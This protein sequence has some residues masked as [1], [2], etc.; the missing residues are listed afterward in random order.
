MG[1]SAYMAPEGFSGTITQKIDIY[2]FGIVLLELLTGL[3]SIVVANKEQ[4]NIK[5]YV[6]ENIVNDDITP[7]LDSTVENWSMAN[8]IYDLANACLQ[9]DRKKRLAIEDVCDI[10]Y[11][12]RIE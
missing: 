3:K 4:I 8:E 10:L 5:D 11:K 2:S 6:E 1:T 12:I 9:R 7:L